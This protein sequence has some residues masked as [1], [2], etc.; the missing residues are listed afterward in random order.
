MSYL[1]HT[2]AYLCISLQVLLSDTEH[3]ISASQ[4]LASL[5]AAFPSL[6]E[7]SRR[8]PAAST[9]NSS[10]QQQQHPLKPYWE[11]LSFLFRRQ[12]EPKPDQM[13]EL[14]YRDYLQ[15]MHLSP[16]LPVVVVPG[17]A[18]QSSTANRKE[19]EGEERLLS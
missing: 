2:H 8:Q 7:A 3:V 16:V 1:P 14:S 12:P 11:Y 15:V 9:S 19:E 18:R 6:S 5:P 17:L 4:G 13:L 10:Q